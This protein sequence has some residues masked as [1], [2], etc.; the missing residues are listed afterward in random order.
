MISVIIPAYNEATV[1]GSTVRYLNTHKR[2][3]LEVIVVDGCSAD[4]TVEESRRAGASVVRCAV[5]G[6]AAQMNAGAGIARGSILY[7]VHADSLPPATFA[8][9]ILE[10]VKNGYHAG[11]YRLRFDRPHW[12]LS[13]NAWFTRFDF[14]AFRFGDQSL[15]VTRENFFN[16]GGFC[17]DHRVMEDQEIIGR[18]KKIGGFRVME[19]DIVTSARRYLTNGVYKTQVTFYMIWLFYQFGVSQDRLAILLNRLKRM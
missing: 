3:A 7:F 4:N 19:K 17:E 14:D 8:H 6:R 10:A 18:L 9:D 15:F 1:I 5:R 16:A 2:T 11:C 13:V 12:F